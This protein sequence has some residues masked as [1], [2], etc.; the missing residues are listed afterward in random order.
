VGAE[1]RKR[2]GLPPAPERMARQGHV[3]GCCLTQAVR[4]VHALLLSD[5]A[6]IIAIPFL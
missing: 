5:V 6:S 4:V 3:T 2:N 1:E